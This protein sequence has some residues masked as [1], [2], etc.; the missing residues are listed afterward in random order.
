MS[1]AL[2]RAR[3]DLAAGRAWRARDRLDG[4]LTHR[5]DDEVLELLARVH[6]EMGDLPRAGA[7][8][9]VLRGGTAG[10]AAPDEQAALAAWRDRFGSE[11]ARWYSIPSP[12]RLARADDLRELRATSQA[13]AGAERD[14]PAPDP[15]VR[16]GVVA[17]AGC[18]L[19]LLVVLVAI[20][21]LAVGAVTVVGLMF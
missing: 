15:P 19:V 2:D 1:D 9:Y 11:D 8:F 21:L 18:L 10:V 16:S 5:Q 14:L 4:L 12:V 6:V 7:L 3:S 20:A 17:V 13:P